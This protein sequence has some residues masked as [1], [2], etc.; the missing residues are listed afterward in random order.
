VHRDF[1]PDNVI[2]GADGRV[3]VMDFGL[4]Q[5]QDVPAIRGAEV[6][7]NDNPFAAVLTREGSVIGTPA[8]MAPELVFGDPAGPRSDQFAFGMTLYEALHGFRPYSAEE[9]AQIEDGKVVAPKLPPKS[10]VPIA[11]HELALRAV[12]IAPDAR[13][14]SMDAL[15]AKLHVPQRRKPIASMAIGAA[16]ATLITFAVLRSNDDTAAAGDPCSTAESHVAAA[17]N[18]TARERVKVRFGASKRGH[19]ETTFAGVANALDRYAKEL[20]ETRRSVCEATEVRREQSVAAFDL[21]MRCLGERVD[22]LRETV[23]QFETAD[24][25]LVDNALLATRHLPR[26]QECARLVPGLHLLPTAAQR[27]GVDELRAAQAELA[28]IVG[29]AKFEEGLA[30]VKPVVDKARQ[31]DYAPVTAT[32]LHAKAL[33][34]IG[35][36]RFADAERTLQ[37][38]LDHAA[39]GKED[40]LQARLW[41]YLILVVGKQP[42]R[43]AEVLAL[44]RTAQLAMLRADVADELTGDLE[45]YVGQAHHLNGKSQEAIAAF[46][47]ALAARTKHYGE[48]DQMLPKLYGALGTAYLTSMDFRALAAKPTFEK[49]RA[50]T[51]RLFGTDHPAMI[52]ALASLGLLALGSADYAAAVELQKRALALAETYYGAESE[53]T[54]TIALNLGTAYNGLEDY[55]AA[56]PYYAQALAVFERFPDH[57]SIGLSIT[58]LADVREGAGDPVTAIPEAERA[59]V[60]A[61]RSKHVGQVAYAQFVLA[62]ALWSAKRDKPRARELAIQARDG[63]IAGGLLYANPL[64][65]VEKWL[66]KTGGQR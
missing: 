46:E 28:A 23:R 60:L 65:H 19:A 40:V 51:E 7:V 66:A 5:L 58:G 10:G 35:T 4:A 21:R 48:T 39:R 45:Y 24:A 61:K 22:V 33:A 29:A 42:A 41:T 17:W 49:Q 53:T 16:A 34:E 25:A 38:A 55:K 50:L 62:K 13:F 12:A 57:A 18:A 27:P 6:E 37:E 1:K 56:V 20:G 59:L 3:R 64:D 14:A 63:F 52:E 8:Y 2:V 31:V 26:I 15:L 9:L 47:K 32:I 44:Y 11:L 43:Y 54:G 30:M 36:S